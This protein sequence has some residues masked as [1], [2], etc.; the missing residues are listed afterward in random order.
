MLV[1]NIPEI[2]IG[3]QAKDQDLFVYDYKMTEDIVKT[4]VNLGIRK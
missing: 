2:Y 4:K 3:N 1:E